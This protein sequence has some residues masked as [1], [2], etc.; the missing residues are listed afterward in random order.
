MYSYACTYTLPEEIIPLQNI[1]NITVIYIPEEQKHNYL[2]P[3]IIAIKHNT[4]IEFS[5]IEILESNLGLLKQIKN[6]TKRYNLYI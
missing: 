1:D 6:V 4:W 3:W 2:F 5:S